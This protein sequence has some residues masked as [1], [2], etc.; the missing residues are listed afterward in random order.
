MNITSSHKIHWLLTLYLA[1]NLIFQFGLVV[2]LGEKSIFIL[3]AINFLYFLIFLNLTYLH[4]SIVAL[5]L[6]NLIPLIYFDIE[7]HYTLLPILLQDSPIIFLVFISLLFALKE[8]TGASIKLTFIRVPLFIFTFYAIF[9]S[10]YGILVNKAQLSYVILEFLHAG[11]YSIAILFSIIIKN[12]KTYHKIFIVIL[13]VYVLI[14]VEYIGLTL[15]ISNR[16]ATFQAYISPLIIG[17]IFGCVL[18]MKKRKWFFTVFSIILIGMVFTLTRTLWVSIIITLSVLFY[19]YLVDYLKISKKYVISFGLISFIILLFVLTKISAKKAD[20]SDINDTEYRTQSIAN[21]TEDHSFL[22]R[23][24]LGYY[25]IQEFT[26]APIFGSGFGSTVFYKITNDNTDAVLYPDN[27]WLYFLWKG[28]IVGFL[29]FVWIY[30]RALKISLFLY[31]NSQNLLT[32]AI[33]IG[34]FAGL[35]GLIP[36]GLLNAVLIKYKTTIII[37]LVL[38]Y[39]DNEHKLFQNESNAVLDK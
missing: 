4:N 26:K 15:L 9:M 20:P 18:F 37:G 21:P 31:R 3:I 13:L 39:L 23:L 2:F 12:R 25:I 36:F 30:W 17:G 16:I 7:F 33:S 24:E 35:L 19:F 5:F 27:S 10:A 32:K 38:A 29:L 11:Y 14:S 28:G 8:R 34:I 1:L 6:L 22:M